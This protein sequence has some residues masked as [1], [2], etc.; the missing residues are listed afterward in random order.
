M[1]QYDASGLEEW[2]FRGVGYRWIGL[3]AFGDAAEVG[4]EPVRFVKGFGAFRDGDLDGGAVCEE[5][6][7]PRR[8]RFSCENSVDV[9]PC[10]PIQF[11]LKRGFGFF[12]E[13]KS[14]MFY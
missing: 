6:K 3:W 14:D 1:P 5:E 7:E 11:D 12:E 13:S 4:P 8:I 10:L 2:A 9:F